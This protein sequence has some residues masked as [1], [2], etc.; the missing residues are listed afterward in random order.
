MATYE[1]YVGGWR[2]SVSSQTFVR[3]S[4][5]DTRVIVGEFAESTSADV[6][7]AGAVVAA[8]LPSGRISQ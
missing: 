5:S 8:A 4:P 7:R 1:N 3:E 2:P 6:D